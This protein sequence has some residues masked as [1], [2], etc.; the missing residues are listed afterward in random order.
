MNGWPSQV[1][2]ALHRPVRGTPC[3][4]ILSSVE[5]SKW[6]AEIPSTVQGYPVVIQVTGTF[7]TLDQQ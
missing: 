7:R 3:I 6:R 1:S 5:A 4:L 2:R